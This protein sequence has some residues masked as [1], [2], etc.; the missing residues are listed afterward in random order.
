[1][2]GKLIPKLFD[3]AEKDGKFKS[4]NKRLAGID[5]AKKLGFTHTN[6]SK[7]EFKIFPDEKKVRS[8]IS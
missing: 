2:I 4:K 3:Q 8:R 6:P 7:T 5:S 1:M